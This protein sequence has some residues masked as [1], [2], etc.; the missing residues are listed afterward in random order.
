[1][2]P[3]SLKN[4][5]VEYIKFKHTVG[6]PVQFTTFYK[7]QNI[8]ISIVDFAKNS[9]ANNTKNRDFLKNRKVYISATGY[10]NFIKKFHL[11]KNF[12]SSWPTKNPM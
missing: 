9:A 11:A 12:F 7:L 6:Q 1:M 4:K 2:F 10:R 8:L 5:Y 3:K